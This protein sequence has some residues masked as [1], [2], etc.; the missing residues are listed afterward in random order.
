MPKCLYIGA[1][2]TR[3]GNYSAAAIYGL[4]ALLHNKRESHFNLLF[5]NMCMLF[6]QLFLKTKTYK[7][8]VNKK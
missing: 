2:E 1:L 5:Y 7:D 8:A 4:S 6:F 3:D